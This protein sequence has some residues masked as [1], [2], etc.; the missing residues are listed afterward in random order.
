METEHLV[1]VFILLA[2][3]VAV[4][5][6]TG[7]EE[8]EEVLSESIEKRGQI[9]SYKLESEMSVDLGLPP[10]ASTGPGPLGTTMTFIPLLHESLVPPAPSS[11]GSVEIYGSEDRSKI[12]H[13]LASGDRSRN[14]MAFELPENNY[15]CSEWRDT[16]SCEEMPEEEDVEVEFQGTMLTHGRWIFL[17]H[18]DEL[19]DR[20]VISFPEDT[21]ETKEVAG[22]TCNYVEMEVNIS[23]YLYEPIEEE[24]Q[25]DIPEILETMFEETEVQIDMCLDESTGIPVQTVL[26]TEVTTEGETMTVETDME[27]TSLETGVDI[28]EDRF[29]LPAEPGERPWT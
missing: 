6:C 9:E 15:R 8:P 21:V 2:G 23:E 13:E 11:Q 24:Y 26:K 17:E 19:R 3:L 27:V 29:E 7:E 4:G 10:D 28:S 16:W 5:G 18:V 14:V 12:H 20:G 1:L 22:R 25:D